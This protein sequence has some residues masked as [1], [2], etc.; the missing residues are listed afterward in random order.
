MGSAG[1]RGGHS[2]PSDRVCSMWPSLTAPFLVTGLPYLPRNM[3]GAGEPVHLQADTCWRLP[4]T[5]TKVAKS[6]AV[7]LHG[8]VRTTCHSQAAACA[9]HRWQ[10]ADERLGRRCCDSLTSAPTAALPQQQRGWAS[11]AKSESVPPQKC[12]RGAG[13]A[14]QAPRA[15]FCWRLG[16]ALAPRP[17]LH[18]CSPL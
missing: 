6:H 1:A 11:R 9:S 14:A 13:I 18:C 8:A 15:Y 2:W 16:P 3:A 12:W 4:L 7:L 17:Q 10:N 5:L